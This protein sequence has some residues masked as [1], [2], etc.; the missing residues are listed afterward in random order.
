MF[1]FSARYQR[2][3]QISLLLTLLASIFAS[4]YHHPD[5]YMQIIEFANS[6]FGGISPSELPWE[7]RETMRP[8]FQ[9]GLF[10]GL[11][12]FLSMFGLQN[13]F[14]IWSIFRF[15]HGLLGWYATV[16]LV[17]FC[18]KQA[19]ELK[20][21]Q[22]V[23]DLVIGCCTFLFYLPWLYTRGSS[24]SLSASLFL[25]SI[26]WILNFDFK[27]HDVIKG[28]PQIK[29][30]LAGLLGG[31]SFLARYQAGF[32]I[33]GLFCWLLV[34]RRSKFLELFKYS[35]GVL[36]VFVLGV[37]I[38]SWGYGLWNF[39]AYQYFYQNIILNKAAHWGVKPF[40]YYLVLLQNHGMPLHSILLT[41]AFFISIWRFPRHPFV[42]T[43]I[44]FFIIH[45][46]VGHKEMRFLFPLAVMAPV[47]ILLS[48]SKYERVLERRN[49]Y[50]FFVFTNFIALVLLSF[51]PSRT[52]VLLQS[53]IYKLHPQALVYLGK[54][55]YSLGDNPVYFTRPQGLQIHAVNSFEEYQEKQKTE[56]PPSHYFVTTQYNS[57]L[58]LTH[59]DRVWRV[60]PAW[61]EKFIYY[62]WLES[63]GNYNLYSCAGL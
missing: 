16:L 57:E 41:S 13:P 6:K 32:F 45:S 14:W 9:P 55:P 46:L 8:W 53:E 7:Y 11:A 25:I 61:I 62:R 10:Y 29:W 21:N 2:W 27:T 60:F 48:L 35:L 63:A 58:Q 26:L 36:S 59:C 4:G 37:L 28:R 33:L 19:Q 34:I 49:L 47:F 18:L 51:W 39:S 44:P 5:E 50:R 42:W 40:W 31:L 15:L 23:T 30:F 54:N 24:E 17:R 56:L 3:L 12:K 20:A 43:A 52:E 38:D 22:K 1:E